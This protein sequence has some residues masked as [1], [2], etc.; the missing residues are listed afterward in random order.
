LSRRAALLL[1]VLGAACREAPAPALPE[2]GLP[3]EVPLRP[4]P[5]GGL[6]LSVGISGEP[7]DLL[8]DVGAGLTLLTP[9]RAERLGCRPWG[10]L[11][12][13][14]ATGEQRALERC[15]EL[16]LSLGPLPL[17]APAAVLDRA[18]PALEASGLGGVASLQTLG[19]HAVTLDL[20]GHRLVVESR[21][22]LLERVGAMR[23]VEAR[24]GREAGG[25]AARLFL[26]VGTSRGPLWMLAAGR[27]GDRVAIAP[28]ALELLGLAPDTAPGSQ[29]EV[30]L[31]LPGLGRL[32]RPAVVS[33]GP[34]DGVLDATTLAQLV[35]SVD[36]RD[37]RVWARRASPPP[38]PPVGRARGSGTRAPMLGL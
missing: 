26:A 27:P 31:D 37:G 4:L 25:V 22:S 5:E 12:L 23:P 21:T 38:A 30:S 20:G 13:F 9:E 35:L 10:R 34:Y 14:D 8:L 18:P 6:A 29:V 3:L 17:S 1:A 36:L 16:S 33:A 28:H 24:I 32:D 2:P 7:H 15:G 19:A 11:L